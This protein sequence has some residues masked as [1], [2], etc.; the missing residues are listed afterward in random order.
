MDNL[1]EQKLKQKQ[2]IDVILK[3]KRIG[4][5]SEFAN[6]IPK[7]WQLMHT[8]DDMLDTLTDYSFELVMNYLKKLAKKIEKY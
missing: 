4:K 5:D 7:T 8:K 2:I 1:L 6:I 3:N